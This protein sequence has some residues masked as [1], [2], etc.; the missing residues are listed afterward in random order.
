MVITYLLFVLGIFFLVNGAEWIVESS[1]SIAKRLGVSSLI[2][3][4]TVVA[5]GTSL[6]EL[7]VN[8]MAALAGEGEIAFGNVIGSNIANVLLVLGIAALFGTIK[9]KRETIWH[10]IPFALLVSFILFAMVGSLFG[11]KEYLTRNDGMILLGLFVVFLYYIFL[12][13]TTNYK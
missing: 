1:S 12:M 11:T 3:G 7:V 9:L 13:A 8:V 6:P 4:L 10:E 5:F 2:I